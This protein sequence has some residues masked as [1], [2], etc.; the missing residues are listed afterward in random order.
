MN[1]FKPY[2]QN[3]NLLKNLCPTQ[4]GAQQQGCDQVWWLA[5]LSIWLCYQLL[6]LFSKFALSLQHL[7]LTPVTI[8]SGHLLI[9]LTLLRL[10]EKLYPPVFLLAA[11]AGDNFKASPQIYAISE[12]APRAASK[13]NPVEAG[14]TPKPDE[15]EPATRSDQDLLQDLCRQMIDAFPA[16]AC[17]IVS[18]NPKTGALELVRQCVQPNFQID[19]QPLPLNKFPALQ[20]LIE[21]QTSPVIRLDDAGDTCAEAELLRQ[22][23]YQ[24]LV[25][26]PL[27]GQNH[28]AALLLLSAGAPAFTNDEIRLARLLVKQANIAIEN[29]RLFSQANQQLQK[30][31]D[32]L[33]GLQRVS[34]ELN[35]TL[36]LDKI[37]GLVLEEAMRVTGANFGNV[38]LYNA[39]TGNLTAYKEQSGPL[40]NKN[41]T[42]PANPEIISAKT[43]LVGRALKA[44]QSVLVADV[45]RETDFVDLNRGTRS[46]VVVPVL[47]GGEPVGVINL[48]SRQP[49]FFH[50]EHLRYLEA[51]ANHA[52]IAIG[53][54]QAY[55]Q[56]RQEREQASRRADQL[57]RLS[58]ISN[59][60]RTNRPLHDVLEDI[61]YAIVEAV[62]YNTV[63][64]S[65]ARDVPPMLYHQVGAGIPIAQLE[66]LQQ[67]AQANSLS[68][69]QLVLQPEFRIGNS[70]FIPAER[71]SIWQGKLNVPLVEKERSATLLPGQPEI[72]TGG[73]QHKQT[74]QTGDLLLVPLTDTRSNIIG[75]LSVENPASDHQ[76]DLAAI[77]TLE[78][79]ANHAAAAIENA[80]LFEREKQR[81]QLAD[82]MRGVAEAIS[83]QLEFD[84]LLNIVLQSLARVVDYD[85]AN[86]QLLEGD[87]LVIIGGQGWEDSKKVVGLTFS[88][89]GDNPN[90]VVIET[91]EP[92]IVNDTQLE[93]PA[94]FP[95]PLHHHIRSWLGVP[96]T[97]GTHVLGLMAL[98]KRQI[99]FFTPEDAE[100]VL[101]FANQVAVA[102]QNARLFEEARRQVRQLAALTEVAQSLNRALELNE[103][104]NLV[105]D[106]VFDLVG[107]RNGSIWL[108]E[109]ATNTVKIAN[110]KN[111]SPVLIE[112]FNESNITTDSEPFA[113]VIQSGRVLVIGGSAKKDPNLPDY[114]LPFPDD[115]T[116]VPLK[117]EEGVIGILA[118]EVVIHD[119]NMLQLVT[120]LADLAAVA[121]ESARL[122]EDTR[123]RASEMQQLY[124]LGVEVSGLLNARQVMRA[125]IK[126]VLTLSGSQVGAILFWDDESGQYLIEGAAV[127][128]RLAR[129]FGL[130]QAQWLETR[131]SKRNPLS[132]W[133]NLIKQMQETNQPIIANLSATNG[134]NN[135]LGQAERV[136]GRLGVRAILGV[137]IPA[138][139]KINGAIFVSSLTPRN[140]DSQDVQSLSLV[141]NQAAVAVHNA[142]LV[143]RLNQLTEELEQRVALRTEELAKTLQDLTEERDRVEVLYRIG[144][145]LSTSFDL[146]RVLTEALHLLNRAIGI[147]LGSILLLE[148]GAENLVYRAALGR[149]KPLPRGGI[150]T[151]YQI[152][153][154]LAGRVMEKREPKLV[155][156]LTA[157]PDWI[158]TG[159]DDDRR[160]AIVAPLM[161]GDDVV[162]ALLL[163]HPEPNYFTE[164]QL[165]LVTAAGAQIA[166]AVNN[167][168]LYRL[169][170]D[171]AERLGVMYR[172]QATEAAKNQAILK[173]IT[174]GV[175]VLDA[176][177]KIVLVNPKAAE[178]LDINA[179]EVENQPL[180]QILGRS[181]S[182]VELELARLLH[183]HLLESLKE[184]EGGARSAQF[185]IEVMPKALMVSLAPVALGSEELP[186]IVAVLRDISR[187]AEVERLKNEFIST[188]SHELRTP[189]TSIKGYTDLLLSE[190]EKVGQLSATQHRF[191]KIIQANADRLTDL[192]NDILEIS[193][194]ETG[195]IKLEFES[196][197]ALDLI[198]NVAFMFEAQMA[199]KNLDFSL[200]LPNYL[201]NV[202]ADKAR[203]IQVLV[204][205]IGN[206]WQYT[207]AGGQITVYAKLAGNF[208]QIDVQDTGIGIVEKD[209]EYI[210]ERFFRSE[211]TEVQVVDG[212][213]LGLSITKSFVDMLGGKIWV[214]SQLDVGSVFSFTVP[215]DKQRPPKEELLVEEELAAPAGPQ[216]LIVSDDTP[217]VN[218]L[219]AG[220]EEHGYRVMA[221]SDAE[222]ALDFARKIGQKLNLI[223]LD[224]ALNQADSFALL[225]Q[226]KD[227]GAFK[228][229]PVIISSLALDET[230]SCF[231]PQA[232]D[233]I[234]ASF[235]PP[236]ILE[237]IRRVVSK[238]KADA[239]YPKLPGSRIRDHILLVENDRMTSAQLREV[240]Q[241]GGFQVQCAYNGRQA[242]DMA[243]GNKPELILID[244]KMPNVEGKSLIAQLR[245]SHETKDVPV[246][247][248]TDGPLG[249]QQNKFMIIFGRENWM[250]IH[251]P[252]SVDMLV[253]EIRQIESSLP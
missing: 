66:M 18:F 84:D 212:T 145:E 165:R 164:E 42:L 190:N 102:L 73:S 77:Q 133:S 198:K 239:A 104:L 95:P 97:Y 12:S 36:D 209:L 191:V 112:L 56:Q 220:F 203:F 228:N 193:R 177:R 116:Y 62:G 114:E 33:A 175:L 241:S 71:Q 120:T 221:V 9:L 219:K 160:S 243:V 208:V 41:E 55:L 143:R 130:A 106:A 44:G 57:A 159:G 147:S 137:P 246:V 72:L 94:S 199:E 8:I 122:L 109:S 129:Q 13:S 157:D 156:D 100:V 168:E 38:Y 232:I 180:Q 30:R 79:F 47:Y 206:A 215:L 252:I 186:S 65:L 24:T 213:G 237:R 26:I 74:W 131:F 240:L 91:Q 153:V 105:L 15:P 81:R 230:G 50:R 63:L 92:V 29:A 115:V 138:K 134:S 223:L 211:R 80:Q 210:F 34:S 17:V 140:F 2:G 247:V 187:E 155:P 78:T 249:L 6:T 218:L 99:G 205:L 14:S 126:N 163:F 32:E 107:Q 52:A 20:N 253:S 173:G 76:P 154:G 251:R 225:E 31:L 148:P 236:K 4:L 233:Y 224:A 3:W 250:E 68:N 141:A 98:D 127:T 170:T 242:I 169:I 202:Y 149:N 121:I 195:R 135:I 85:S 11:S 82:T 119:K 49:D 88:M 167:A 103:V 226:I 101:A 37:L 124:S 123:R 201:P 46:E 59:A 111:I 96:L 244:T 171:Q 51:L 58:E 196:L 27:V 136:A 142:E 60:F 248:I 53:N 108:I 117:T 144:R 245:D 227:D 151:A 176:D 40:A 89:E 231:Y 110:T 179:A 21:Q 216:L 87:H 64:I 214:N 200:K 132:L 23:Q 35:S 83:A 5:I 75:L 182:P 61:A 146:D 238:I 174:D 152:G 185:R 181:G 54:A 194:I 39:A 86:V 197:D 25:A 1:R 128:D 150:E 207:P 178:I 19:F 234:A 192:V 217:V 48:E 158:S 7:E 67:P 172:Q 118:I 28:A 22:W 162:G 70:Y 113:S 189:M 16:Q 184:I 90:R 93:Y 45:S 166:I 188:V 125:V 204:N 235:E 222:L 161:S 183:K 69:L 229:I 43:G 139:N 10:K